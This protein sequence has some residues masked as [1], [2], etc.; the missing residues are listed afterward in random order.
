M[1]LELSNFGDEFLFALIEN[2]TYQYKQKI[3]TNEQKKAYQWVNDSVPSFW[4]TP[5][6]DNTL[7]CLHQLNIDLIGK[8]GYGLNLTSAHRHT[9]LNY[10]KIAEKY[11][12][13][14]RVRTCT[15]QLKVEPIFYE[16]GAGSEVVKMALGFRLDEIERTVNL[17]FKYTNIKNRV[18]NTTFDL[19]QI[20]NY[21]QIP[22]YIVKWWD[23]L[24]VEN[25]V[26]KGVLI[27]K[28]QPFNVTKRKYWRVPSFPLIEANVTKTEI[29]KYWQGKRSKYPFP[30]ISNCVGCFHH[31]F[32]QLKKQFE[33]NS[34]KMEWFAKQEERIGKTFQKEKSYR[35]LE[36]MPIQSEIDFLGGTCD[37]GHCTD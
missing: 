35:Q 17:Y 25:Q 21:Y 10:D 9:G 6:D 29:I 5:E 14:A 4:A 20:I 37:I 13:N 22:N 19:Q 16:C 36:K 3:L 1:A 26:K 18:Q 30:E 27:L 34:N 7:V 32:K 11:L 33:I 24:D 12:P 31:T 15:E 8:Y 2:E 23:R 28:K